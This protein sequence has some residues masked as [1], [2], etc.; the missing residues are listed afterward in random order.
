VFV[1]TLQMRF[2]LITFPPTETIKLLAQYLTIVT[3]TNDMRI[4]NERK[5]TQFHAKSL[6]S[7]DILG[8][9]NRILKYSP[10]GTECFLSILIYLKRISVHGELIYNG[11]RDS[12]DAIDELQEQLENTRLTASNTSRIIVD[13]YNIHRLIITSILLGIKFQSDVFYTNLHVSSLSY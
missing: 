3:K 5:P 1:F 6:P 13:S 12:D 4:G 8:Y 9:L 2:E 7:I 10:C 11:R